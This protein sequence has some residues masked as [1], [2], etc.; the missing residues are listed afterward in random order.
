MNALRSSLTATALAVV[1]LTCTLVSAGTIWDGGGTND[2]WTTGANWS[3]T[4]FLQVA[5]PNNGTANIHMAGTTRRTPML[6]V[7]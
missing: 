1:T 6:N 3:G 2:K 7:P 5:P 4:K